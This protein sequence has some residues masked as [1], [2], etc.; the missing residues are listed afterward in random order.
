VVAVAVRILQPQPIV[1]ILHV[2]T[3]K[4]H[5]VPMGQVVERLDNGKAVQVVQVRLDR[6]VRGETMVVLAVLAVAV[7]VLLAM[8]V[9]MQ[10]AEM[11]EM[12]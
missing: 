7:K 8:M 3:D 11:A 12:D 2:E 9:N 5:P 4:E 10:M 1:P 6:G